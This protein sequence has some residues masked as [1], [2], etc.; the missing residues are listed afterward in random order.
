MCIILITIIS[1]FQMD[2]TSLHFMSWKPLFR[3]ISFHLKFIYENLFPSFALQLYFNDETLKDFIKGNDFLDY[4]ALFYFY[5]NFFNYLIQTQQTIYFGHN[6]FQLAIILE[7]FVRILIL[8]WNC[9][10]NLRYYWYNLSKDSKEKLHQKPY[11]LYVYLKI[12]IL[13]LFPSLWL[14]NFHPI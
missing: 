3:M 8:C 10:N 14:F 5:E 11:F 6:H 7:I 13:P 2:N 4:Q 1:A 9:F 12:Q